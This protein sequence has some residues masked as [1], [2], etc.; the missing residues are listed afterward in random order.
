MAD[1]K[2]ADDEKKEK[3]GSLTIGF[4]RTK[5]PKSAAFVDIYA[6]D[7]YLQLTPWDVRLMFSV[8]TELGEDQ[9]KP[10]PMRV[11]DV[12]MSLHHAK[13]VAQLLSASIERY[14]KEYGPLALPQS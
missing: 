3:P 1:N 14:E 12:R 4:D 5:I 6:N 8:L 13:R 9:N 2:Q 7:T 11:V 10:I